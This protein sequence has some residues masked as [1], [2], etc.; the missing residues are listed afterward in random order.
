MEELKKSIGLRC[1]FCHSELFAFPHENYVPLHGSLIVCA[2]CGREN[3]VTSL[4]FVVK[5]KAMDIAEDYADKLIDKFQKD[6]KKAFKGSK[7]IKFR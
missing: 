7:H 3:D 5:A 6:L 2:N 4:I 1:T